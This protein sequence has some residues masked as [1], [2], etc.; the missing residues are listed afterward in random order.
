[1]TTGWPAA[2][3]SLCLLLAAEEPAPPPPKPAPAGIERFTLDN[4]LRVALEPL[5]AAASAAAVLLFDFGEDAD[6]PGRSGLAHLAEH[7]WCTAATASS[8]ARTAEGIAAAYPLGW[9]AQTGWDY[10]VLASVVPPEGLE[11]ELADMAARM[12]TLDPVQADLDREKPRLLEE[13]AN[14]YGRFPALAATNHAREA[15]LRDPAAAASVRRGGRPDAVKALTLE[16]VRAFLR[17]RYRAGNARLVIAGRFDPGAAARSVRERFAGIPRGTPPAKAAPPA[18]VRP[19]EAPLVVAVEDALVP[20]SQACLAWRGPR[21]GEEGYAAFTVLASRLMVKSS[22]GP[23]APSGRPRGVLLP[24]DD[25][26]PAYLA[27]PLL[28]GE[29]PEAAIARLR[30]AAA[31]ILDLP[32]A[33]GRIATLVLA[34]LLATMKVPP[35]QAAQNP[36]GAAFGIGR[37]DQMGIDGPALAKEM[38]ALTTEDLKRARVRWFS[39]PA[40]VVIDTE[41]GSLSSPPSGR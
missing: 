38:A 27:G 16:E 5:P 3:G 14:M 29:E 1:M 9:N 40:A 15:L 34:P 32:E 11:A 18:P 12:A 39:N 36:Y 31:A 35:A 19:P 21:P 26:G 2:L 41:P 22:L 8:P 4:G 17:E 6:P 7:L 33:D 10:T 37:R 20:G 23:G 30:G 24:L 13:L 25:P 28:E